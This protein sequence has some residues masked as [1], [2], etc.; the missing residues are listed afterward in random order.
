MA[1][2]KICVI[3][4]AYNEEK[5]IQFSL[6]AL[7]RIIDRKNIYVVCDGS[8]D[9][10][11]DLARQKSVNVMAL[12]KNIGKS[13]AL[14]KLILTRKLTKRYQYILFS[15]ADSLLDKNFLKEI[16]KFLRKKPALI[17]GTVDSQKK[18]LVSA[19]R[20]YEYA[21]GH[22]VYKKAQ[23]I[24]GLV[25]VAPGCASIYRNDVLEKINFNN[26][27]VTEDFD[28]TIQI[29]HKRLGKI[30]YVPKAVSQTQD[31]LTIYDYWRQILR[32]YTGTWQNIFLHQLYKP[33]SK[34]NLEIYF[35]MLDNIIIISALSLIF[36]RPILFLQYILFMSITIMLISSLIALIQ[37]KLWITFYAPLFPIFYAINI[38]AYISSFFRT[39]IWR[40][41]LFI[42]NKVRRY[43]S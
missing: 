38:F 20:T 14:K 4:P 32:W 2:A 7:K 36:I 23:N 40:N 1:R 15:D 22:F 21:L 34:F 5:V 33:T 10:T 19:F 25:T 3:I 30:I 24:M 35:L 6:V 16:K 11:A 31:P 41:E 27:T 39:I 17:L 8:T 29:H 13:S 18:G 28:F 9:K 43:S 12:R 26:K 42:W 37:K